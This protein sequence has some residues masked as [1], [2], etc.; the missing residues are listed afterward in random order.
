M[1]GAFV[2]QEE[3]DTRTSTQGGS[4]PLR[5][6]DSSVEKMKIDSRSTAVEWGQA[7]FGRLL[8]HEVHGRHS[9]EHNLG[10]ALAVQVRFAAS[11]R[12]CTAGSYRHNSRCT[13]ADQAI[14]LRGLAAG[15]HAAAVE[16]G[17]GRHRLSRVRRGSGCGRRR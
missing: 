13:E 1:E 3:A 8:D 9:S 17:R 16:A 10:P 15:R 6:A 14:G 7:R 4:R 12:A 2:R 5:P 11:D